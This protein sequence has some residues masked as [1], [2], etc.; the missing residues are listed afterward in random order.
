MAMGLSTASDDGSV[1]SASSDGMVVKS[2]A[3]LQSQVSGSLISG[4]EF[5]S[6]DSQY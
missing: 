6:F 5:S 4:R 2:S 3:T 1:Q